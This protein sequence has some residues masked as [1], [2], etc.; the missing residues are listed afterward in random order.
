MILGTLGLH[1]IRIEYSGNK[2]L[3]RINKNLNSSNFNAILSLIVIFILIKYVPPALNWTFFDANFLGSTKEDCTGDGACW[4]FVKV[5]FN[6]FMY[7]MYPNAEQWRINISFLILFGSIISI[8]VL[9]QKFKKYII[10]F[11]LFIFPIIALN[12]N[13]R[14]LF[15][16]KW[17]ETGAWGGLSLT[18]IVSAFALIFCFPIG[19]F[20]ALG[21]RSDL[22]C[23]KIFFNRFYRIVE[24]RTFNNCFVYVCSYVSNVST[25][26]HLYG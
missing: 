21:R 18:F 8:F 26:R 17:I 6:R 5:W 25:R 13:I 3:D 23:N 7:G 1:F 16:L 22:T 4:V 19:C 11:L 24:G 12:L 10:L 15:G 20:L 2:T 9:P 14:W